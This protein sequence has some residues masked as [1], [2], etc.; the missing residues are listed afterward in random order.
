MLASK[1]SDMSTRK[2]SNRTSQIYGKTAFNPTKNNS[3]YSLV[4][5]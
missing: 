4:F 3:V 5:L 1:H 2:K